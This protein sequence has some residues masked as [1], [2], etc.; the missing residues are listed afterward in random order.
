MQYIFK[1]KTFTKKKDD[2]KWWIDMHYVSDKAIAAD[3]VSEA[4]KT[5]RILVKSGDNISISDNA[6]R[7]KEPLYMATET[8]SK[9][10]GYWITGKTSIQDDDGYRKEKYIDM[11]VMILTVVDTKF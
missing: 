3:N 8:G 5:Y 4:I 6:L 1:T 11:E 9:Q 7:N 2:N 10:V